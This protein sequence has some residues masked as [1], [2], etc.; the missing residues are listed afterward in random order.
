MTISSLVFEPSS[1]LTHANYVQTHFLISNQR[2]LLF[3]ERTWEGTYPN[4]R[5]SPHLRPKDRDE[6]YCLCIRMLDYVHSFLF[7]RH[8]SVCALHMVNLSISGW[9][10]HTR[11]QSHVND[12]MPEK[13]LAHAHNS[14]LLY[15]SIFNALVPKLR[16]EQNPLK[17][18][19]IV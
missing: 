8:N 5:I 18:E 14:F 4:L 1:I 6:A 19:E 17:D 11:R 10:N 12:S 13:I 9:P 15:P 3:P 7:D 16:Q 2:A